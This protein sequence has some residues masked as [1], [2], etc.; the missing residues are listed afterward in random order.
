MIHESVLEVDTPENSYRVEC[1]EKTSHMRIPGR[2]GGL[3]MFG[4][5]TDLMGVSFFT[6]RGCSFCGI[7]FANDPRDEKLFYHMTT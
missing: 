2:E 1:V 3:M 6:T 4:S 5:M 7:A